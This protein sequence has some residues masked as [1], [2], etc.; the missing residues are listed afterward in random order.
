MRSLR[1]SF[2]AL[3]LDWALI[4]RFV[5]VLDFSGPIAMLKSSKAITLPA[6]ENEN[7]LYGGALVKSLATGAD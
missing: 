1:R 5:M 2:H 6:C 3:S 7:R 4:Y